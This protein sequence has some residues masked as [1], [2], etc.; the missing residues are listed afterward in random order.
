[1]TRVFSDGA[2][3][4]DTLFWDIRSGNVFTANPT[5]RSGVYGYQPSSPLLKYVPAQSEYYLRFALYDS[6]AVTGIVLY[7]LGNSGATTLAYLIHNTAL[8]K[9]RAYTGDGTLIGTSTNSYPMNYWDLV[10]IYIKIATNPNGRII[11][12]VNGI[13]EID[14]TGNTRTSGY[15]NIDAFAFYDNGNASA[16]ID[17]LAC[18]N[19]SGVVDN[20]WCG[21]EHYE[22][23]PANDNGDV[24]DWTGSDGDKVNNY[25]LVDEVPPTGDTDYVKS[26][27]PTE[28]DMYKITAFTDAGKVVTRLWSECRARDSNASAGEIKIG[29]KTGGSVYLCST[30]RVLPSNYARV[31][32]DDALV[33]PADS[34][35]W[36]KADIDALQFV[37]ETE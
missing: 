14:F 24:N 8:A 31:V 17:D 20:S 25:A 6:Q 37:T 12:K 2:E 4:G 21:D 29:F 5:P 7:I 15:D 22:L 27:T 23:H 1:M 32:G 36:E 26:D 9:Y 16:H 19:T 18:N 13:T 10:E 33:N 30:D 34:G 11:V 35:V 28:Q 3:Y